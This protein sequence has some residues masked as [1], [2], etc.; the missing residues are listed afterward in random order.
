MPAVME[1]VLASYMA[2]GDKGSFALVGSRGKVIAAAPFTHVGT[3]RLSLA[4]AYRA[5][6][7]VARLTVHRGST[8]AMASIAI[9]PTQFAGAP[10][11]G[12]VPEAVTPIAPVSARIAFTGI[13][14]AEGRAVAGGLLNVRLMPNLRLPHLELQDASGATL[15]ERD[16]PSGATTLRLP[17]PSAPEAETYYLVLR[18]MRNGA[19][20]TIV[21]TIVAAAR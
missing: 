7:I 21:R 12:S 13:V 11:D 4:P 18:Y 3:S 9:L 14:G 17:L 15:A 20:E 19:E 5:T 16:I 10:D 2:V 1:T 6:P 8:S